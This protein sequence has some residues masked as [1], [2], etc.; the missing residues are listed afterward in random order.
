MPL[1][2]QL[3]RGRLVCSVS[4]EI[5]RRSSHR[6]FADLFRAD[7]HRVFHWKNENFPVADLAGLGG[8]HDFVHS[9]IHQIIG[10]D[11]FHFHFREK[12]HG[13]LAAAI[14]L[15]V[16]LLPAEALHFR[17][18][19][20]FNSQF[21]ERLFDLFEL[22][23]FDNRFQFFHVGVNSASRGALQSKAE[24]GTRSHN[25]AERTMQA[26]FFSWSKPWS[27]EALKWS[28]IRRHSPTLHVSN[29]FALL[30]QSPSL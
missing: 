26:S 17:D 6:F 2:M 13:V 30:Q 10:A 25:N 29:G 1:E 27:I 19:H 12:V 5:V 28:L 24:R 21:G 9:F 23:R 22:E 14:N 18:S 20:S 15:G 4:L 8:A 7:A 3:A 11:D 16:T